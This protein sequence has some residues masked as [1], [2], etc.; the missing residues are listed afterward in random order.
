ML[1]GP[2]SQASDVGY[3]ISTLRYRP[4]ERH[5]LRYEPSAAPVAPT[6]AVFAK[7]SRSDAD[8]ARAFRVATRVADR[9]DASGGGTR[10]SEER[11]VGKGGK[12]GWG[13]GTEKKKV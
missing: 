9:L 12:C 2:L 3:R 1:A 6:R 13:G 8:V 4:G 11:R 7:L 10:R 5:V